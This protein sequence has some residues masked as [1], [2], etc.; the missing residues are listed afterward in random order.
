VREHTGKVALSTGTEADVLSERI[1]GG[2]AT[3][4]ARQIDTLLAAES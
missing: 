1:F 4:V 3:D 2:L